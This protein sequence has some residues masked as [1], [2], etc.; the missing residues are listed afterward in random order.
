MGYRDITIVDAAAPMLT[1]AR[2]KLSGVLP[3]ESFQQRTFQSLDYDESFDGGICR[4]AINYL[5]PHELTVGFQNIYRALRPGGLFAFNS[6]NPTLLRSG[7]RKPVRYE[8]K[9]RITITRSGN[10]LLGQQVFHGQRSES[11]DL[12]TGDYSLFYDLNSFWSY[13]AEEF[14]SAG[15]S[16]GFDSIEIIDRAGSLY[17]FC[18]KKP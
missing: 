13:R 16:A 17:G 15:R 9:D 3:K 18:R 1:R 5:P 2:E 11:Y 14:E 10:S 12:R 6:F 7:L 4:Q 8:E